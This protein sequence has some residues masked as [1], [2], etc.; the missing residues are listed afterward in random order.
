MV[1]RPNTRVLTIKVGLE[2]SEPKE[3]FAI[4]AGSTKLRDSARPALGPEWHLSLG[5]IYL[6]GPR[7]QDDTHLTVAVYSLLI[8]AN[9]KS[10][11]EPH[12]MVSPEHQLG[13]SDLLKMS[14]G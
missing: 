1:G 6:S 13:Q 7:C 5:Y 3:Q 14:A 4:P 2:V 8:A 9:S 11:D 10:G 12:P